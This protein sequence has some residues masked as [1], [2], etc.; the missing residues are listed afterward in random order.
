MI[1]GTDFSEHTRNGSDGTNKS[2]ASSFPAAADSLLDQAEPVSWILLEKRLEELGDALSQYEFETGYSNKDFEA[3][4]R[5]KYREVCAL[6]RLL[7]KQ[8]E[9][10]SRGET[11]TSNGEQMD[12]VWRD[13]KEA[14]DEALNRVQTGIEFLS[15]KAKAQSKNASE[16]ASEATEK[17]RRGAREL[18][19]GF[20][21]AWAELKTSFEKAR[22]SAVQKTD[23]NDEELGNKTDSRH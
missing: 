11:Q 4:L 1:P 15:D 8:S 6:T 9:S 13:I 20:G 7:R 10:E 5:R 21:R 12:R 22:E 16:G 14:T 19:E 2:S 23:E 18:G 17:L 3:E